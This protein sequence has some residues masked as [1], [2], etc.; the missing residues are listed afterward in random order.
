MLGARPSAAEPGALRLVLWSLLLVLPF[1]ECAGRIW[2]PLG[3]WD[4]AA[5]AVTVCTLAVVVPRSVRAGW[6]PPRLWWLVVAFVGV[7]LLSGLS[8]GMPLPS[9]AQGMRGVTPYALTA[10]AAT[11]VPADRVVGYLRGI[12]AMG[13]LV[14]AYGLASFVTFRAMGMVVPHS[15]HPLLELLLLPYRCAGSPRLIGPFLNPNHLGIWLAAMLPVTACL[16]TPWGKVPSFVR[17]AQLAVL[18][19]TI[20]WTASRASIAAVAVS[21]TLL[22]VRTQRRLL[23]LLPL[24]FACIPLWLTPGHVERYV[25]PLGTIGGCRVLAVRRAAE[26]LAARPLLGHGPG[27]AGLT[28]M[29]YAGIVI[30]SGLI[31]LAALLAVLWNA[32]KQPPHAAEER[33]RRMHAGLAAGITAMAVGALACDIWAIPQL[34]HTF[35]M[36]VGFAN[37]LADYHPEPDTPV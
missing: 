36:L 24:L 16:P 15:C 28:D 14:A 2:W 5:V 37:V 34:A 19:P 10:L 6:R 11:S 3:A 29:H 32:L 33:R 25:D 22:A 27:T 12:S 4:E 9:I 23:L 1:H 35:W 26:T 20:A 17:S 7:P 8:S 30:E 18:A 13:T 31:G 21:V